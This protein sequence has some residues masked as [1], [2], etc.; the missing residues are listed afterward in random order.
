MIK[1]MITNATGKEMLRYLSSINE[2]I[3]EKVNY[4]TNDLVCDIVTKQITNIDYDLATNIHESLFSYCTNLTEVSMMRVTSIES[5]AFYGCKNLTTAS[6]GRINSMGNSVFESC[7]KLTSFSY[8]PGSLSTLP[9]RTFINCYKLSNI[10]LYGISTIESS[11]F[12]SCSSIPKIEMPSVT[13]IKG[14]VFNHCTSLVA[15]VITKTDTV[16]TL[17]NL[18]AFNDTPISKGTGYIYVPDELV[19][20]YKTA[21]NWSVYANQIKP[22]S[23]YV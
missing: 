22:L 1:E 15:V 18:N 2:K 12:S 16:C 5:E 6:F 14:L 23:E 3:Y 13:S 7:Y 4:G 20:Q 21:T 19:D 10:S 8:T 9:N 17:S 11:A